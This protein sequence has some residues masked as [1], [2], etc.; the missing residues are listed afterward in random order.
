MFVHEGKTRANLVQDG[1]RL[2]LGGFLALLYLRQVAVRQVLK[3]QVDVLTIVE[4]AV[5]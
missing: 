3:N 2:F 5:H 4:V 1:R